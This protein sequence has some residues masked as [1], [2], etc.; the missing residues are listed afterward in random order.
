[1]LD[2]LIRRHA[3]TKPRDVRRGRTGPS[4]DEP[5]TTVQIV[6]L[7]RTDDDQPV[8]VIDCRTIKSKW[9]DSFA[10][11]IDGE[12]MGPYISHGDLVIL[13]PSAP[14]EDGKAAVVQLANQIGVTCKLFRRSG[15][16][17]HLVPI[18]EQFPPQA[19]PEDALVWG[20][21]VLARIRPE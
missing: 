1:M 5:S 18:N 15:N 19:F 6:T 20:L 16:E 2:E 3:R 21:R 9:P 17:I 11:Q 7:A 12:S 4:K 10:V 14:A 13:S 8:Q